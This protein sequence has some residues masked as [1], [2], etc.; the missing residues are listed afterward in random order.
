MTDASGAAHV[1]A[2][3]QPD[4]RA[5]LQAALTAAMENLKLDGSASTWSLENF[6]SAV[7]AHRP[8]LSWA[9]V[10][11]RLDCPGFAV[12][13]EAAFQRLVSSSVSHRPTLPL[14]FQCLI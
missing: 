6:A 4:L 12:Q 2:E 9:V 3:P 11:E 7:A 1:L 5:H 10:A 14:E 13:S 8:A